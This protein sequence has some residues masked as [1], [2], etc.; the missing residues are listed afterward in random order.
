MDIRLVIDQML[1]MLLMLIVGV[2][3]AKTGVVDGET[4]RRLSRFAL[5]VPQCAIILSSAMNMEMELTLG[6][7]LA[8]LG[9]AF[10]MYALLLAVGVLVPRL[11]RAK[12]ENRGVYSFLITFGN[13]AFMGFPVVR[14]IYGSDA[15][16][17]AALLNVPFNLLAF[18]V[19]V[20]MIS[21]S[22]AKSG[23]DWRQ[24]LNGPLVCS[25]AAVVMIFL[26]IRWP[27][28][29]K[30]AV[31]ALGDMI[32]PLSMIIVGASLGGQRLG[33]VFRDWR[34][35]A[36]A[37]VRLLVAPVLLWAVMR[38]FISDGMLLGV[39]TLLGGMPSAALSAMLAIQYGANE[40]L[41]TRTVFLTTVLSVVTIPLACWLLLT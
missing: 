23:L 16:F 19:G 31:G 27:G 11:C 25:V 7:V 4:N 35:Y 41:A 10:L 17:Y 38:L 36:L 14:A 22:R 6:R 9:L 20:G 1:T 13:V 18:T 15:V 5:A 26:P 37:P 30:E 24:V 8:V 40:R 33:D 21:G 39:V 28:P 3:A 32:L 29:V 34:A 2:G 12:A